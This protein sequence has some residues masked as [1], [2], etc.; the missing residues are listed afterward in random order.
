[1]RSTSTGTATSIRLVPTSSAGSNAWGRRAPSTN[2]R[3]RSR[4]PSTNAASCSA[5]S[6]RSRQDRGVIERIHAFRA[7]L[8]DAVAERR[9]ATQH[10]EGLFSPSLRE[11][12]DLNY[13]R[14]ERPAPARDLIAEAERLMEDYFHRRVIVERAGDGV[15]GGFREQGWAVTPHLIMAH[16]REP[17]RRVDTRMVRE[18]AF[19][20]LVAARREVTLGEPWGNDEIGALLDNAKRLIMRAVPTRFYAA[21]AG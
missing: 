14:A 13:L 12:Y 11:V 9:V 16:A 6:N 3:S 4:P 19:D 1:M 21:V 10:A 8:Q 15:A 5:A 7:A 17:D 18:V 20:E 2:G